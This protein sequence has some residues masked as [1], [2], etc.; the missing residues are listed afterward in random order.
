MLISFT[1]KDGDVERATELL[2]DAGNIGDIDSMVKY[3]W[4]GFRDVK[5]FG[6]GVELKNLLEKGA[7][8]GNIEA[9]YYLACIYEGG[10]TIPRNI[11]LS[12]KTI[13]ESS[14]EW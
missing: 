9:V 5:D 10:Y 12:A 11:D 13:Q 4:I 3:A 7:A 1:L 2:K 6:K 8:N 14:R